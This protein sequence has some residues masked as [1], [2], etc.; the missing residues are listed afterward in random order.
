[1]GDRPGGGL[2][3][4][5]EE[6]PPARLTRSCSIPLR[7]P[8]GA[9]SWAK[10]K[11]RGVSSGPDSVWS[12]PGCDDTQ[13]PTQNSLRKVVLK[14]EAR[15]RSFRATARPVRGRGQRASQGALSI[16]P[17]GL[18]S[19]CLSFLH[20]LRGRLEDPFPGDA[21]CYVSD[22]CVTLHHCLTLSGPLSPL[23]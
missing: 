11:C 5:Q 10:T 20:L 19:A 3:S 15:G 2:T 21:L 18:T 8:Q 23:A 13:R 4:D 14:T 22:C 16:K 17:G 7:S 12:R 1:M 6:T 9:Y